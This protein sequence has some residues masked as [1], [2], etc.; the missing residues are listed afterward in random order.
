MVETA[1]RAYRRASRVVR[2]NAVVAVADQAA[3]QEYKVLAVLVVAEVLFNS[4]LV[5]MAQQT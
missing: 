1:A 3:A 2:C 5:K 4:R